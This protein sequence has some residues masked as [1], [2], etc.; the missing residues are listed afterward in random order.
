MSIWF[1]SRRS[2]VPLPR[3]CA[4]KGKRSM[5]E[6]SS[7]LARLRALVDA[8]LV[9]VADLVTE[10]DELRSRLGDAPSKPERMAIAGYLHHIYTGIEAALERIVR[11]IDGDL[12]GG[13]HPHRELLDWAR[14]AVP[15]VRAAVL[16]DD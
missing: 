8:D 13:P 7:R 12:P 4:T 2:A 3:F 9:A 11:D 15:E 16:R 1:R 14:V 10:L 6:A 5:A